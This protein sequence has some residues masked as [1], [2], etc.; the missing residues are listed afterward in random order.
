MWVQIAPSKGATFRAKYVSGHARQHSLVSCA[1]MAEPIE[2][3]FGMWTR[4][5]TRKRV[6]GGVHT[7]ATWRIPLNRPFAV[8]MRRFLSN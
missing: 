4:V 2:M 6:L 8:A 3:P 7:D 1:K 5:S